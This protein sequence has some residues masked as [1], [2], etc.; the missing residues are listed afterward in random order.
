MVNILKNMK[1]SF[2]DKTIFGKF[3]Y[4]LPTLAETQVILINKEAKRAIFPIKLALLTDFNKNRSNFCTIFV[5]ILTVKSEN[6]IEN[7]YM[8]KSYILRKFA[9]LFLDH[10]V[11][12]FVKCFSTITSRQIYWTFQNVLYSQPTMLI[13]FICRN[14]HKTVADA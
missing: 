7:A 9:R 6:F 1:S 5:I 3:M 13:I 14:I 4:Q 8:K 12:C 10:P 2:I 11:H